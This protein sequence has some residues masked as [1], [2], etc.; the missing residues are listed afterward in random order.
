MNTGKTYFPNLDGIRAFACLSVFIAHVFD[1]INGRLITN[2]VELW[3]YDHAITGAGPMGVSL[4]FVLSGFL[5]TYLLV[6]EKE[7]NASISLKNFYKKRILRIWP[8][9]FAVVIAGFFIVP[10]LSG[11][12]NSQ[13]I[14]EHLPRFLIFTNNFDR[15]HTGFIGSGNDS[16]GVLW[17]VAVEEQFY[18]FWPLIVMLAGKKILPY[19]LGI[20]IVGSY[21]FRYHY[22]DSNNIIF[23]HSLSVTG[24]LS[25]GGLIAWLGFYNA[26]FRSVFSN[27]IL[28]LIGYTFLILLLFTHNT[29]L[30]TG[31]WAAPGRL[32][33][34]LGFAFLIADQCFDEKSVLRI[35]RF[36]NLSRLGWISY[37]FYCIHMFVIV[38]FQKVNVHFGIEHITTGIFYLE[39]F[40][41][42]VITTGLAFLSY[43]YFEGFFLRM[44]DNL[45]P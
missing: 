10:M 15:I 2:K 42:F 22:Q 25:M 19:L 27:K 7:K 29:L 13:V 23:Y 6:S 35:S 40:G 18:L 20:F 8:M 9:F 38:I 16:L 41:V 45:N 17:S 32:L 12:I 44:K 4:F 36:H 39:L 28:K 3:L 33:L 26:G 43:R 31:T 11:G 1:Y 5:I 30:A 14:R 21:F 37:G 34:T 24:D